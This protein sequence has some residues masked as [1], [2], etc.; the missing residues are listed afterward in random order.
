MKVVPY[1][2]YEGRLGKNEEPWPA[3]IQKRMKEEEAKQK[4]Q[5]EKVKLQKP[6]ARHDDD[7]ENEPPTQR[8]HE[9]KRSEGQ[10]LKHNDACANYQGEGVDKS[11]ANGDP[12]EMK[13]EYKK[14]REKYSPQK[15]T[16]LL[17]SPTRERL[18]ATQN[19]A[20]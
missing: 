13:L 15:V 20:E 6:S 19:Y 4:E 17:K 18:H 9:W 14:L 2:Q 16:L 12:H 11:Q 3:N 5:E 10:K 1:L 8:E 7:K